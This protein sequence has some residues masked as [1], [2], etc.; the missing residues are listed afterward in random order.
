MVLI[1][2]HSCQRF[3]LHRF[4]RRFSPRLAVGSIPALLLSP[5]VVYEALANSNPNKFDVVS[6]SGG[7]ITS[8]S[9]ASMP[10]H[11]ESVLSGFFN[12]DLI[13]QLCRYHNMEFGN[14]LIFVDKNRLRLSGK[15]ACTRMATVRTAVDKQYEQRLLTYNKGGKVSHVWASECI[16]WE[17][18][19]TGHADVEQA[20]DLSTKNAKDLA[21]RLK[22]I[23]KACGPDSQ[24]AFSAKHELFQLRREQ[25]YWQ[26]IEKVMRDKAG[27]KPDAKLPTPI[28]VIWQSHQA[29]EQPAR[30]DITSIVQ[31]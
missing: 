30:L 16:R 8:A 20:V 18:M 19:G 10:R 26:K 15:I 2:R 5:T 17:S 12:M 7:L 23:K 21:N 3:C 31:E 6:P 22:Q 4:Q 25:Y 24:Q 29:E 13:K 14:K 28:K 1:P 9:D 11:H 27:G